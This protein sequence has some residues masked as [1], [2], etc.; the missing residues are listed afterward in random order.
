MAKHPA[1]GLE[2]VICLCSFRNRV[3]DDCNYAER[4]NQRSRSRN[5]RGTARLEHTSAVD[6]ASRMQL[7]A[8]AG[9]YQS[10]H[11]KHRGGSV[12]LGDSFEFVHVEFH[13]VFWKPLVSSDAFSEGLGSCSRLHG[14]CFV[15][16][17]YVASSVD[18]DF[19]LLC[20]AVLLLHV[21]PRRAGAAK[22]RSLAADV[23]LFLELARQRG[24]SF[25]CGAS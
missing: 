12:S 10:H 4:K 11:A 15:S 6:R 18:L 20:R 5:P 3:R 13:F 17:S 9:H 21:L 25:V 1:P 19:P 24:G 16:L 2:L 14:L 22:A 23:V 7:R 8:V